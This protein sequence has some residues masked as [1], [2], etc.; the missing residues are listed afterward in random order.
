MRFEYLAVIGTLALTA[1]AGKADDGATD[2]PASAAGRAGSAGGSS[3]GGGSGGGSGGSND[4]AGAGGTADTP[5]ASAG[6]GGEST[7]GN[8]LEACGQAGDLVPDD[9]YSLEFVETEVLGRW[10]Y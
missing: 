7:T 10:A 8:W 5:E 9:Q 6:A 4:Q 3:S 1:C 2:D